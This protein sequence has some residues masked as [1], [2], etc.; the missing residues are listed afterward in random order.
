MP[1]TERRSLQPTA[2]WHVWTMVFVV[3]VLVLIMTWLLLR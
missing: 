1:E 3:L 2:N